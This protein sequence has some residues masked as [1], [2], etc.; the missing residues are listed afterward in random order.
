ML[1]DFVLNSFYLIGSIA[2]YSKK[3]KHYGCHWLKWQQR[4]MCPKSS[5]ADHG[6]TFGSVISCPAGMVTDV[7]YIS[8]LFTLH[9]AGM[10]EYLAKASFFDRTFK[11]FSASVRVHHPDPDIGQH[12]SGK[13]ITTLWQLL[14]SCIANNQAYFQCLLLYSRNFF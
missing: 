11:K 5:M 7:L 13:F 3:I 8:F 10:V 9:D 12:F 14:C 1:V 2:F 4:V 6:L